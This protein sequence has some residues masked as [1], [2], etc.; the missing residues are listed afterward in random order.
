MLLKLRLLEKQMNNF[1]SKYQRKLI[2]ENI[3]AKICNDSVL[4]IP[5]SKILA[6]LN[7]QAS[8][9]HVNNLLDWY[10]MNNGGKGCWSIDVQNSLFPQWLDKESQVAQIAPSDWSYVGSFPFGYW[11]QDKT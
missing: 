1:I 8:R 5:L 3:L 11:E 10:R 4:G 7:I 2:P 9:P 6:S